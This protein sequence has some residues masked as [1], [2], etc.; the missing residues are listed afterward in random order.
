MRLRVA[1]PNALREAPAALVE[2]DDQAVQQRHGIEL[3]LIR[4]SDTAVKWKRHVGL[5]GPVRLQPGGLARL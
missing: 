2:F 5:V 1:G 4:H 3:R